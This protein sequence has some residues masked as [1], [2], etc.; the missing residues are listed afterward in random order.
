MRICENE[1]IVILNLGIKW[2]DSRSGR[3]T[4]VE[5]VLVPI[6]QQTGWAPQLVWT[7]HRNV[8]PACQK[9]KDVFW[10]FQPADRSVY[11]MRWACSMLYWMKWLA[12]L[13]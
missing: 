13:F 3:P 10:D 1:G 7:L 8:S 4:S 9:S 12:A 11:W 6:V 5:T 2:L